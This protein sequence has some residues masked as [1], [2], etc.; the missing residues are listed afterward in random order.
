MSNQCQ[1]VLLTLQVSCIWNLFHQDKHWMENSIETFWGDWGKTSTANVQTNG[2]HSWAL[3]H[4]NA[5]A[6]ALLVVW[7]FSASTNI[8]V[9]LHP[10]YSM[11]LTPVIFSYSLRWN[12][13]S[14]SNVLTALKGSRPNHRMWWRCWHVM[15]SNSA[16]D[17]RNATGIAVSM[18]NGNT[19]K[20][21]ETNRNFGKWLSSGSRISGTF[22]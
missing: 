18:Q 17:H 19:S 10:S 21:M 9:I 7:Q 5:L 11:D 8:T 16:S 3:H 22:V 13:S 2:K 4:D 15:T 1:F 12:W 20:W 14:R 6:H